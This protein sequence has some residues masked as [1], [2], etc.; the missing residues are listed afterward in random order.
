MLGLAGRL[1]HKP[2]EL[3]GGE[4]PA[5]WLIARAIINEPKILLAERAYGKSGFENRKWSCRCFAN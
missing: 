1:H 4:Q 5:V 3:S 2:S